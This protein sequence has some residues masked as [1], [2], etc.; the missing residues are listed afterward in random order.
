MNIYHWS[1]PWARLFAHLVCTLKGRL[2][3]LLGKPSLSR[4]PLEVTGRSESR[5]SPGGEQQEPPHPTGA[6]SRAKPVQRR[7]GECRV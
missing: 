1:S 6:G 3:H 2:E 7:P 5:L 4:P